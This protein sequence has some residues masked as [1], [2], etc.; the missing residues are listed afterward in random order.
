MIAL[1]QKKWP[2]A[3][4]AM[5]DGKLVVVTVKLSQRSKNY[6]LSIPHAGGPLLTVP[7]H[8]NWKEAES[9][10]N[11][12]LNW[13]GARLKR[14]AKP[15]IFKAGAK[16]PLRGIDHRISATGKVR[17]RVEVRDEEGQLVLAVPGEAEHRARRL[18]DWLKLEAQ[19]DL[20]RRC[21]VHARQLGVEVKAISMRSQSTRWGSCSSN[22]RLN[23][24]WRLVMAPPFVLDYVAAH[25]VAHLVEMNHSDRFWKTVERTLPT[26]EK[27]REWLRAHGRQLM[28]YGIEMDD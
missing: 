1:L 26:M 16:V 4:E 11:R 17:G 3:T 18:T 20:E 10:L 13:L 25:E 9:F 22:G 15:V 14:A 2:S 19:K 7:R 28:V 12:Q 27:G 21:A 24:N 6:R 5:I 23:F 8:G